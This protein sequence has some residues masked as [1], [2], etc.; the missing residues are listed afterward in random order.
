MNRLFKA[1]AVVLVP[2]GLLASSIVG[3]VGAPAATAAPLAV[4]APVLSTCSPN[5]HWITEFQMVWGPSS[6]IPGC[7][8]VNI[9]AYRLS[10]T[11]D[12]W[13]DWCHN[14]A[15]FPIV[16]TPY[17][18]GTCYGWRISDGRTMTGTPPDPEITISELQMVWGPPWFLPHNTFI[19][20]LGY[21]ASAGD[22]NWI[23]WCENLS[24]H[25]QLDF[26]G[27]IASCD[28]LWP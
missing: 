6:S 26:T 8:I 19:H 24:S 21:Q 18:V 4:S 7:S 14:L 5:T 16:I 9:L 22:G 20:I 13:R 28:V 17:G 25:V 23:S 12:G 2:V 3:C 1:I 10:S 15:T 11:D 27:G